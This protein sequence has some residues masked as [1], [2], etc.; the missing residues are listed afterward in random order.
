MLRERGEATERILVDLELRRLLE[1]IEGLQAE[2][3]KLL[4]E[5]NDVRSGE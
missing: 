2:R 3:S 5:M 4:S 1:Q